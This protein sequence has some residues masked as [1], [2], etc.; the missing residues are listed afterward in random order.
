[1]KHSRDFVYTEEMKEE[2]FGKD[3]GEKICPKCGNKNQKEAF[4]CNKCGTPLSS[5]YDPASQNAQNS[6]NQWQNN[7]SN[8][9]NMNGPGGN[10]AGANINFDP[11]G[12]VSPDAK[13]DKGVTGGEI[14][15]YVKNNS[16]YFL[17][18]FYRIKEFGKSRFNFCAFLFSGGYLL[19]RKQYFWGTIISV[20]VAASMIISTFITGSAHYTELYNTIFG[21]IT[22]QSAT[23][24]Q[25]MNSYNEILKLPLSDMIFFYLPSVLE[26][27]KIIAMIL[28]GIFA[29]RMYYRHC[30]TKICDIKNNSA[31]DKEANSALQTKG[32]VNTPLAVSLLIAYF[33]MNFLPFFLM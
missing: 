2:F 3:E 26:F 7:Q 10:F 19:Y 11:M 14:A 25:M 32:G 16:S 30:T 8:F 33:I 22:N 9:N 4:F 18:V 27:I 13:F 17:Q 23:Y 1:E 5:A 6:G 29:N 21:D 20:I 24:A 15:K 31:D 28:T 12:G